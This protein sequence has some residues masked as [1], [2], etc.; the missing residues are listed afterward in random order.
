MCSIANMKRQIELKKLFNWQSPGVGNSEDEFDFHLFISEIEVEQIHKE[1]L[2][3]C[4]GIQI[5]LKRYDY[6]LTAEYVDLRTKEDPFE[7]NALTIIH[8]DDHSL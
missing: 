5:D 1:V 4:N 7:T 8:L 2:E 3:R 6:G